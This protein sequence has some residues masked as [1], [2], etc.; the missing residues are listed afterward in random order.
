MNR[1]YAIINANEVNSIDF[2]Q[3]AE[4][5]SDTLRYNVANTKTFVKYEGE[6][7]SFLAGKTQ[8][9]HA[10]FLA[11]IATDEWQED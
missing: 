2:D 7:P 9:S 8:Y 1:K 10:E 5:S 6:A 11:I 3:V 4:T